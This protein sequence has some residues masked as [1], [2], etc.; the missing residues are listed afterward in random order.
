MTTHLVTTHPKWT[1]AQWSIYAGTPIE[2]LDEQD[3][4]GQI[5]VRLLA[6]PL[7]GSCIWAASDE[8]EQE[9]EGTA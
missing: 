7:A 3:V 6:G 1:K 4:K 2:V 8:I 5:L 9:Q